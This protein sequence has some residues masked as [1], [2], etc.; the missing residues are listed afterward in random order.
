MTPT[1][2]AR[3]RAERLALG[4]AT[5]A[6]LLPWA[7]KPFH[8]DDPL[9]VWAA[10]HI[11]AHPLD[12]YGFDVL[13]DDTHVHMADLTQNPPGACYWLALIGSLFGWGEVQLHMAG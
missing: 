6:C 7:G 8:I 3:R 9:F 12:P 10:R 1:D 5:L 2:P 11:A 4:A 13:W